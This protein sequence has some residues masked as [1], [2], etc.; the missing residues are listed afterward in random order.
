MRKLTLTSLSVLCATALTAAPATYELDPAHSSAQFS[1]RHLTVSNVRGEFSN[2]SGSFV[3]DPNDLAAS[4]V[5]AKV[6]TTT[7]NTRE[8]NRDKHLKSPDFFDVAKF[9]EMTFHSTSIT[10]SS[11]KL[12]LHGD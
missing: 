4:K 5:E 12:Q 7:I 3:Y 6:D 2:V 8:P 1:V 10:R 9:P 11:G